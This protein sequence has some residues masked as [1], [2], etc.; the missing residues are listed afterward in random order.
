MNG[1]EFLEYIHNSANSRV[2]F[3]PGPGVAGVGFGGVGSVAGRCSWDARADG[4][5]MRSGMI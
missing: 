2:E 1:N 5:P 3:I 4:F